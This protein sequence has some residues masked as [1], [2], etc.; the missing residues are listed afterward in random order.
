MQFRRSSLDMNSPKHILGS[1]KRILLVDWPST[2]VPRALI[3]AGLHVFGS[4]PAGYSE[5][6]V[7]S[8]AF[9]GSEGVSVFPPMDGS[10]AGYLRFRR[11]RGTPGHV[12]IVNVFRPD[13][14]LES[15]VEHHVLPLAATVLWLQPPNTSSLAR[16]LAEKHNLVFVEGADIADTARSLLAEK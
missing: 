6:D 1:A 7:V 16:H 2:A 10:E 12:D 9:V 11:L 3:A 5:A 14:E 4:S 8:Q 15:I 13:E